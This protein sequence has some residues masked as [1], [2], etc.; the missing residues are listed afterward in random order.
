MQTWEQIIRAAN[1]D[2]LRQQLA[3]QS[4]ES[5]MTVAGTLDPHR[6]LFRYPEPG[7]P[8]WDRLLKPTQGKC[9][10][11]GY[12]TED[13]DTDNEDWCCEDCGHELARQQE[14]DHRLDDPRHQ[15]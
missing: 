5:A 14:E 4:P 6:G 10:E 11:C 9:F 3:E 2:W 1:D 7:S 13:W 12:D 8:L 15:P